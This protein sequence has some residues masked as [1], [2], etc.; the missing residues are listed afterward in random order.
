MILEDPLIQG[1]VLLMLLICSAFFSSA[2]TALVSVNRIQLQLLADEGNKRAKRVLWIL[3]RSARMLSAILI[4]NN[5]VNLSASALSATLTTKL[6]GSAYIGAATG[7]L[8]FL[9]LVFGEVTPKSLAT[10]YSLKLSL[11]Y[12]GIIRVLM[13]VLVPFIFIIDGI[14]KGILK[15]LHIDPDAKARSMTEDE[16]KTLV[17]VAMEEDAIEE[18]EFQMINNVFSLDESLAKDIMIP[19]IDM[20]FVHIDASRE[21]L[22]DIYR[23]NEYTRYPVYSENR[24]VVIGTINMKDLLLIPESEEFHIRNILREPHFTFEHKEIGTLLMEMRQMSVNL[25]IVLDEYGS[26]SGMITMEDILEEIVG[27]IRDEYDSDEDEEKSDD[28]KIPDLEKGDKVTCTKVNPKQHFSQPPPRYNEA[29]LVKALE[30]HGIGRPST[31]ATIITVIQTRKYVEKKDKALHPTLLGRTVSKQLCNQFADIMDYKFT[32]GMEDKLDQIAE[33]KAIWNKVL[34]DFYTPF[35]KEV[36]KIAKKLGHKSAGI[37]L[38]Y[39]IYALAQTTIAPYSNNNYTKLSAVS[40]VET[41]I[42]TLKASN[43]II[44]EMDKLARE[45]P[46]YDVIKDM[47]GCG[48]KLTSRVIAEIG[49]IKKLK[50]LLSP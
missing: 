7:I 47:P 16:L 24:D 11:V 8:T 20:V 44:T 45:L 1:I 38:G 30:E 17:D 23:E 9:V 14:R 42:S 27:E 41:L 26:T 21:E 28:T 39:K 12:S 22:M 10:I 32:A 2:E 15:I 18:D 25:M 36:D 49:D 35:I 48:E 31:Y 13:V 29:S 37:N 3:D 50:M 40:C 43:T 34:A 19:R 5:I 46:E 33:K 4:G 6:F